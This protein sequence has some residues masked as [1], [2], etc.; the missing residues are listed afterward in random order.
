MA[1]A[2]CTVT[3]IGLVTAAGV[4]LEENLAHFRARENG[5]RVIT[6][7]P[8]PGPKVKTSFAGLLPEVP[9]AALA[10][11]LA[12]Q[13][14]NEDLKHDYVKAACLAT[15]E[16]L[17][18]ADAVE[19]VRAAPSRTGVFVGSSL[20]NYLNVSELVKDYFLKEL[21]KITSLIHGMNS[22]LPSRLA[23]LFGAAGPC[24]FIS[25]S[26][27]SSG[28]ALL[29]A[30]TM[31]DAGIIDRAIVCGVDVCLETGT[32]HLWNKIRVLSQ[33]NDDP[34]TAC[35]PYCATRD[36]IVVAEAAGC[37]IVERPADAVRPAYAAIEGIGFAN[38][39]A[40]F[41]KPSHAHL[42]TSVESAL[43]NAGAAPRDID[44]VIGS[45]SGSPHCD[46]VETI[47]LRDVLGDRAG[48]VP[49]FSFKSHLGSTFGSQAVSEGALALGCFRA[50]EVPQVRNVFETDPRVR[51]HCYYDHRAYAGAT[52]GR[53][54]FLNYGFAGNHMAIV[55]GK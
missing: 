50:N 31:I 12:D 18:D 24:L 21:Y 35:R 7:Y 15:L 5:I 40:D 9:L 26:C 19:R 48:E 3:G 51:A 16:A 20:G 45:A 1:R 33:R 38:G 44:L 2:P 25:S 4:G 43:A 55:Y 41:F 23:A 37:F 53:M 10:P 28:N 47:A 8:L 49:V 29:Y 14:D 11:E 17:R 32:F 30:V 27:T 36:G 39:S 52:L 54:L 34:A 13:L 6:R 42:V 46:H 22:Y